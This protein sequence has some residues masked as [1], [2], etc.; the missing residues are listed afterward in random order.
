MNRLISRSLFAAMALSLAAVHT[1]AAAAG[2]FKR[3]QVKVSYP[4]RTIT[5]VHYD[6]DYDWRRHK[7]HRHHHRDVLVEAPFTRVETR[8]HRRVA[9]DAPFT[10]VRVHRRGV[11]VRAPF[12]DIYV[13]R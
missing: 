3:P 2:S 7:R 10:S 8:R 1:G 6:E 12:V 5:Y 9:V 11:W 4:D 13:P